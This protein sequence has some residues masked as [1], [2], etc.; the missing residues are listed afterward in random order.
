MAA[1]PVVPTFLDL[2]AELRNQIYNYY[3]D[4]CSD[5]RAILVINKDSMPP[6]ILATC[7]Q[8]RSETFE[9]WHLG[10]QVFFQVIDCNTFLYHA[11][12]SKIIHSRGENFF[13]KWSRN[14]TVELEDVDEGSWDYLME[15]CHAVWAR[16]L[17]R[18]T[19]KLGD[20]W[21]GVHGYVHPEVVNMALR[22]AWD[23]RAGSWE[24]G[25]GQLRQFGRVAIWADRAWEDAEE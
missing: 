9:L 22:L 5:Y 4:D 8:I 3:L 10:Q 16:E 17:L 1:T 11:Y 13:R 2:P 23:G 7:R 18:T 14:V 6:P 15:W 19:V 20:G 21:I 25:E 12:A 24:K